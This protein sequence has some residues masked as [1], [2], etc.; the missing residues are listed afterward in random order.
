V[1]LGDQLRGFLDGVPVFDV[2]DGELTAGKIGLY[3]WHDHGAHFAQVRVHE[4][5][6]AFTA[7]T[8]EDTFAQVNGFRWSFSGSGQWSAEPGALLQTSAAEAFAIASDA[9][10]PDLRVSSLMRADDGVIGIAAAWRGPDDHVR[11]ELD[12][13]N[14]ATRLVSRAGGL[15]SVRAQTSTP[16]T[17]GRDYLVTVDVV[18]TRLVAYI[19]GVEHAAIDDAPQGGGRLALYTSGT[20]TARFTHLRAAP[21][22]WTPYASFDGEATSAGARIAARP[23]DMAR[24]LGDDVRLRL[25]E[26]TQGEDLTLHERSFLPSTAYAAA[27]LRILRRADGAALALVVPLAP[28]HM[29]IAM[30]FAR[31]GVVGAPDLSENGATDAEQTV[32]DLG[33]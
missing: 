2:T 10:K 30:Q 29:E 14:N 13:T 15:S 11:F 28:G 1:A 4:P 3:C 32:L 27:A 20:A 7:W 25:V 23:E 12:L 9:P 8:I 18:G 24:L 31:T 19:N 5:S 16:L 17:A 21:A 6:A 33:L 26:R 22:L